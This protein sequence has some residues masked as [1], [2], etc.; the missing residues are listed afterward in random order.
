MDEGKKVFVALPAA[1]ERDNTLTIALPDP[2]LDRITFSSASLKL[3]T[4]RQFLSGFAISED[5]DRSG[6]DFQVFL[7]HAIGIKTLSLDG[8]PLDFI[9]TTKSI[10]LVSEKPGIEELLAKAVPDLDVSRKYILVSGQETA[11]MLRFTGEEFGLIEKAA[12]E[13]VD[14]ADLRRKLSGSAMM[15][16]DE[17][18]DMAA[19]AA[20]ISRVSSY[21]DSA[22]RVH[23]IIDHQDGNTYTAYTRADPGEREENPLVYVG[24]FEKEVFRIYRVEVI[25]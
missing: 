20:G 22:D 9:K 17:A 16:R 13:Y 11:I 7:R 21:R 3:H 25:G 23:Y 4:F 8:K 5:H 6:M 1:R 14:V 19:F 12:K 18:F 10:Y 2:K 24:A 15:N